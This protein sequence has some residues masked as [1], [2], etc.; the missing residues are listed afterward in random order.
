[1]S[2]REV[3]LEEDITISE[4]NRTNSKHISYRAEFEAKGSF[5]KH[6][7]DSPFGFCFVIETVASGER[8]IAIDKISDTEYP[9][10]LLVNMIKRKV[11]YLVDEGELP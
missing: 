2:K 6:P 4:L 11:R 1:M 9:K 3:L 5:P 8:N 7:G 10:L